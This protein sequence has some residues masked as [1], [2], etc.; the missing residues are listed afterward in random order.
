M[1]T[2]INLII[3]LSS[4]YYY[5]NHAVKEYEMDRSKLSVKV[6]SNLWHLS[7]ILADAI[8]GLSMDSPSRL[9]SIHKK[10]WQK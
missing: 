9:S 6:S 1:L 8:Q 4:K 2:S 10:P 5:K 3:H 7:E